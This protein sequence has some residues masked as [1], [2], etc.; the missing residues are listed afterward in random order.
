M[1]HG[2][3]KRVADDFTMRGNGSQPV[4]RVFVA[5]DSLELAMRNGVRAEVRK[6]MTLQ[7]RF[8]IARRTLFSLIYERASRWMNPHEKLEDIE[9]AAQAKN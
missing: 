6:G 4:F 3:V 7:A 8:V 1:L 5:P 9:S 2:T